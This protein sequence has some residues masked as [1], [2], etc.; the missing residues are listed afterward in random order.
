MG[1]LP[2]IP[3]LIA[4]FFTMRDSA[5][6]AYLDVYIPVLLLLPMYYRWVIPTFP[7]PTFEQATILPI[8]LFFLLQ[9][10]RRR[11]KFSFMDLLIV[12]FAG[13]IG[14][15][16]YVN[17]G[18]NEAQNLMFDMIASVVLP[19]MLTKGLLVESEI[20][21]VAL[22][23][24]V[25]MMFFAVSV[26]SIYEFRMGVT[27]WLLF[28]QHFYPT[29]GLEWVT[30]FRYGFA[31]IGGPYGHAIL[32]GL[33]L[34][35]G[36][37]LQRWLEWR[38]EWS[39]PIR[40]LE[41]TRLSKARLITMGIVGGIVMTMVR[42]PWLGGFAGAA[43]TGVGRYRRP[44]RAMLALAIAVMVVGV[45]AASMFYSYASVGRA[46]AKT[47]SQET[48]AYRVELLDKYIAIARNHAYWG[49]GRNTWP[50]LVGASSI[51][52]YYLLLCLM[53]G[54]IALGLL[55]AIMLIMIFRLVRRDLGM[56]MILP[57]GSSLGFTLAGIYVVYAVTLGTVYMGLQAIPVFAILTG[58]S[59]SYLLSKPPDLLSK[60]LDMAAVR[61]AFAFRRVVA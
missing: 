50:H 16:E 44:K 19:Y 39:L 48:A 14:Y 23:K 4:A 58:W 29:Q 25:V 37:R 30:T 32:A 43:I 40:H 20:R 9:Q 56:P 54:M 33:V 60:P 59:E 51:D 6:R 42:G 5:W 49:Y 34:T 28:F 12:G 36:F 41:W 47:A 1:F 46:H 38:G 24:R 18:Y 31:R 22:A 45:P 35:V 57:L 26:I 27:P 52:N 61:P 53:H 11:W 55:V 21:S 15:S 8:A 13:C 3:A 2:V 17:A 7:D 10:R